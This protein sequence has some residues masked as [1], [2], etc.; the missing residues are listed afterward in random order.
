MKFLKTFWKY[1][2]AFGH[3]V[4]AVQSFIVYFL[5]YYL[6]IS[7]PGLIYRIFQDPL[8]VKPNKNQKSNFSAWQGKKE[9]LEEARMQF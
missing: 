8:N 7:I 2:K 4:G 6:L 9:S 5:L 3:K 1:W